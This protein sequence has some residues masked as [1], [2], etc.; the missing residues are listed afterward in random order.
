MLSREEE[1]GAAGEGGHKGEE[2]VTRM[3]SGGGVTVREV[4]GS[5]GEQR[6]VSGEEEGGR[7]GAWGGEKEEGGV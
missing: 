4:G 2:R 7:K 6:R 3:G 1:G 5:A